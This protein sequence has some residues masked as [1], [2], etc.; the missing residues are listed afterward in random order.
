M[1]ASKHPHCAICGRFMRQLYVGGGPDSWACPLA[2]YG[3]E[4]GWEHD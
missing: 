1:A 4:T 3:P 2:Y